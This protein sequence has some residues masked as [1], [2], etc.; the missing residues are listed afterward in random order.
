MIKLI[1]LKFLRQII[2]FL[3][4]LLILAGGAARGKVITIMTANLPCGGWPDEYYYPQSCR[5]FQGLKPDIAFIQEFNVRDPLTRREYIDQAFGKNYVACTGSGD[6]PN[7]IVSRWAFQTW[8]EWPDSEV[9]GSRTFVWAV[10]DI[11]GPI[12]L[13]GV[14]VHLKASAG[15]RNRS[16]RL[17]EAVQIRDYLRRNFNHAEYIVV[18][19]DLNTYPSPA[20]PCLSIFRSFLSVDYHL[21]RD[22]QGR[23]FTNATQ[24]RRY[25]YDW[26][27]PNRML[28]RCH[29]T[30]Y[31]GI[32]NRP[33]RQG[34]VFDSRIFG[35]V[36]EVSP[37]LANDSHPRGVH[38]MAVMKAYNIPLSPTPSSTPTPTPTPTPTL[39]PAPT[40]PS[41]PAGNGE[42]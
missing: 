13:Q 41:P 30:L 35:D 32:K 10:I 15:P 7:A 40:A 4:I 27:M 23:Y 12:D 24:P 5:V 17:R 18:A 25:H 6:I 28:E 26:I 20:E 2:I 19:G 3:F 42:R 21:P 33:Y 11:P 16:K 34:I 9:V 8:G 31:V 14:C 39:P 1:E 29:T 36:S 38:H 22:R 37:I